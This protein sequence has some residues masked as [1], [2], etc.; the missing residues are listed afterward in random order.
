ME[1]V[2]DK[3][4]AMASNIRN[5]KSKKAEKTCDPIASNKWWEL[6]MS[7][8]QQQGSSSLTKC[9]WLRKQGGM[10]KTWHR[11]WFVLNG[12][13]LFYFQK[14]DDVR[15]L[16][17]ISLP[18]NKIIQHPANP[19]DPDKFLLELIPEEFAISRCRSLSYKSKT[20][21]ALKMAPNHETFLLSAATDE[22]RQDW[23]RAIRR[24]MYAGKGGAIFGT[25]LGETMQFERS[26]SARK[27]P[28]IVESCSEFLKLNGLETE[29]LFRL[30]GRMLLV[31][32]LKDRFD[33][34]EMVSL[35][36]E[37]VD[38]HSVASLLKQFLRELPECLIPFNR[39]QE[40]MNIA[41]RFQGQK[42]QDTRLE[43]VEGL[44]LAMTELPR[45]NYNCLKY[46]CNFLHMVA[47][48][49]QFNKM[50][51]RNLARVFGPNIIRHPQMEDNPE[52]FMLTTADI[53]EQLAYMMI[54]FDDKIFSFE[55]DSDRMSANVAV[56]DLLGMDSLEV[57][58]LPPVQLSA[59]GDLAQIRFE[60]SA[61]RRARS[62][63]GNEM[64]ETYD[65]SPVETEVPS[66]VPRK[67]SRPP[68]QQANGTTR[69]VP[70]P[71]SM[72]TEQ[73]QPIPPIRKKYVR[74]ASE[75]HHTTSN[76]SISSECS[77]SSNSLDGTIE[78]IHVQ[79]KS[80]L[81]RTSIS[82]QDNEP[83]T[84][85]LELQQKL[86]SLTAE[87]NTL[88][89]KYENLLASKAKV[90]SR[91]KDLSED[92][93]KIQYTYDT[94]INSL[95]SRYKVQ[96]NDL[97][98]KLEEEKKSRAEAVQKV[99]ELQKALANRSDGTSKLP[100]LYGN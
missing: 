32:D 23:I 64:L 75:I 95:E 80:S 45:D 66:I 18:G 43:E 78:N 2:T 21:P 27:V 85:V 51:A 49:T 55:F 3:F 30:P 57:Q 56:D 14:E 36:V 25:S 5:M 65:T 16:G 93:R 77:G 6:R 92:M 62:F 7:Q 81:S 74:K 70:S 88:Q 84:A 20:T 96:I 99:I 60:Q 58:N 86:E 34:G 46:L 76:E 29:G 89:S 91:L 72:Y 47:D 61:D 44:R 67:N 52:A 83:N 97:N 90:D 39:Y 33:E 42:S 31:R 50:D 40:F 98:S 19:E 28:Y 100:S 82:S 73:G 48:K 11:R 69:P 71:R 41:M 8:S 9:G 35:D 15:P 54:N 53:S 10:V 63:S 17:M 87:H 13:Y 12:D 59:M 24:T 38:V 94:H 26:R 68:Q 4:S 37:E 1:S 79:L 22:E